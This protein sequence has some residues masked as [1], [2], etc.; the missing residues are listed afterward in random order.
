[1]SN[2]SSKYQSCTLNRLITYIYST[3]SP[4]NL[5]FHVKQLNFNAYRQ[6]AKQL[7]CLAKVESLCAVFHGDTTVTFFRCCQMKISCFLQ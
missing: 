1:M 6:F 4:T 3:G 5:K 2:I 7:F